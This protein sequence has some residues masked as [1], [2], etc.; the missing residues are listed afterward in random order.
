MVGRTFHTW[1]GGNAT[2]LVVVASLLVIRM[3]TGPLPT[4]RTDSEVGREDPGCEL[5]QAVNARAVNAMTA[6]MEAPEGRSGATIYD[7]FPDVSSRWRNDAR[8][9][10]CRTTRPVSPPPTKE[11][12]QIDGSVRE[13][14]NENDVRA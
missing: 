14:R 12:S 6:R 8:I 4:T 11:R 13:G 2:V 5:A 1:S 10:F 7:P 9:A 3:F